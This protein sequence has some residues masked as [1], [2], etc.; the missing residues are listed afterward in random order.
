[1]IGRPLSRGGRATWVTVPGLSKRDPVRDKRRHSR[2][3]TN[4]RITKA[5]VSVMIV[6]AVRSPRRRE[7]GLRPES[8]QSSHPRETA[9]C[10]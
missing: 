2:P 6:A 4:S 9:R 7:L 10:R 8:T 1:M 5:T 3:K